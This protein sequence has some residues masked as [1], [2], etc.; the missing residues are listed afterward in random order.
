M[1]EPGS[2]SA[3]VAV[4]RVDFALSVPLEVAP[5]ETLCIVGPSG[6][7]KTTLVRAL[8]GLEPSDSEITLAGRRLERLLP[9]DR[10]LGAVF[11]DR[12]LFPHLSVLDNIGYPIRAS[13]IGR[14]QARQR[15]DAVLTRVGG[16]VV[17]NQTPAR[18]APGE[19]TRVAL[20]RALAAQPRLLIVD[21]PFAGLE[22]A[23]RP[24]VRA[25]L[26]AAFESYKGPRVV[27][28]REPLEALLTGA[29]LAVM[30]HGHITQSGTLT[31]LRARPATRTVAMLAGLSV[32]PG[33]LRLIEDQMTLETSGDPIVVET[34]YAGD[35]YAVVRA[36]SISLYREAPEGSPA[37][38]LRRT[39]E[40]IG[41]E[42][43]RA[44]VAL[45]G[46]PR[47]T[48]EITAGSAERL[49]LAPGDEVTAVFKAT[50]IEL[51]PA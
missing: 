28:T 39:I 50:D 37:N 29:R 25:A 45:A 49:R 51:W 18:L 44:L 5:G 21:E 31:E 34:G 30:E 20:A 24:A 47:L 17:A 6:A 33:R 11:Q 9:E 8:A 19:V 14:R 48:A 12:Y 1:I 40:T 4:R 42:G 7:G 3:H 23:A 22:P 38:A 15:A 35:A 36:Q 2:L 43:K 26:T 10:R 27:L 16:A 13:G 41:I 32:I 46:D